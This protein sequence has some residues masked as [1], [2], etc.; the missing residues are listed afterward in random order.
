MVTQRR[1]GKTV[2]AAARIPHVGE[3][4]YRLGQAAETFP[5]YRLQESEGILPAFQ[6]GSRN[7]RSA[8]NPDSRGV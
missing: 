4:V 8:V 5:F 1:L 3:A 2:T 6:P 7:P